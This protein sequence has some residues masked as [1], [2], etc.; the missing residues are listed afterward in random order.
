MR[1]IKYK[2]IDLKGNIIKETCLV[3]DEKQLIKIINEKGLFLIKYNIAKD[4]SFTSFIDKVNYKDLALLCKELSEILNCGINIT[5]GLRIIAKGKIKKSLKKCILAVKA[6]IEKGESVYK[7]VSMFPEIFPC[8]MLEIIE[9]GEKSGNLDR[10]FSN[11]SKYY[12]KQ[13]KIK[14]KIKSAMIY[15]SLVISITI[16]F[17][18]LIITQFVPN[19]IAG[20]S[21]VNLRLPRGIEKLLILNEFI[22]SLK[23]KLILLGILLGAFIVIKFGFYKNL[24]K[25]LKYKLPIIKGI[26]KQIYQIKFTHKFNMLISSGMPILTCLQ[27]IF[28]ST[29]ECQNRNNILKA[30]ESIKEGGTLSKSLGYTKLFNDRFLSMI[31]IGEETGSLEEMLNT[32]ME[33]N[34]I[35][36]NETANRI[37]KLIE[38]AAMIIVGLVVISIVINIFIP[39]IDAM[40]SF[41]GV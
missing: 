20:I 4:K 26:L 29:S 38:P 34:E 28:D 41:S 12:M 33:I 18:W 7:S 32:M 35:N 5:E 2:A 24:I 14:K 8:F 37:S 11:L 17:S 36:I 23:F 39:I 6:S 15:P 3:Y 13:Y 30:I 9:I 22:G 40:Y 1:S 16:I 31:S 25:K 10:I 19:F 21:E 27:I